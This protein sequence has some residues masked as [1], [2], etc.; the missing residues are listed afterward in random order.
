M[1]A[2]YSIH[3]WIG[4]TLTLGIAYMITGMQK[5]FSLIRKHTE[6]MPTIFLIFSAA[7]CIP[8]AL[9]INSIAL[10]ALVVAEFFLF[11]SYKRDKPY[12]QIYSCFT[13]LGIGTLCFPPLLLLLPIILISMRGFLRVLKGRNIFAAILGLLTPY[14]FYLAYL[15]L[16]DESLSAL[17]IFNRFSITIPNYSILT[18]PQLITDSVIF[19]IVMIAAAH[20]LKNAFYEK[21]RTRMFLYSLLLQT[22][23]LMGFNLLLPQY[24]HTWNLLIIFLATPFIAHYF[25]L[26]KSKS[27]GLVFIIFILTLL[28]LSAINTDYIYEHLISIS[29]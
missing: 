18:S 22:I 17:F 24:Q 3:T 11:T 8:S 6:F 28:A 25:A 27:I 13:F 16:V 20:I 10:P 23:F 14:W 2:D 1:R 9:T 5:N 12:P 7:C 21:L 26:N 15:L 29:F 19:I 4:L